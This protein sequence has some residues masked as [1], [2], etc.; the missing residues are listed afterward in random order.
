MEWNLHVVYISEESDGIFEPLFH[1]KARQIDEGKY[2]VLDWLGRGAT[3][4]SFSKEDFEQKFFV[5]TQREFKEYEEYL[6]E[7]YTKEIDT[8]LKRIKEKY[9]IG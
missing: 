2:E 6:Y 8:Y 3:N 4:V 5:I 7:G 1:F 9:Q